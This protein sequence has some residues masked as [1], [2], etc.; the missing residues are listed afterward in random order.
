MGRGGISLQVCVW[1][2]ETVE[3]ACERSSIAVYDDAQEYLS[4]SFPGR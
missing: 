1:C 4:N 2:G 3:E